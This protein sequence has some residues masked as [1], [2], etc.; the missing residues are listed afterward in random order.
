MWIYTEGKCGHLRTVPT[1]EIWPAWV[2][3]TFTGENIRG[4]QGGY[5]Q[6]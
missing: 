6:V 2:R 1:G 3:L 5:K 4:A